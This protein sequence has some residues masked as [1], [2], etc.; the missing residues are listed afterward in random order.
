M[1]V[2]RACTRALPPGT[3]HA[4]NR[5]LPG[6]QHARRADQGVL[7]NFNSD[8]AC[9]G[10]L[11]RYSQGLETITGR[12]KIR[13]AGVA[14]ETEL[15]AAKMREIGLGVEADMHSHEMNVAPCALDWMRRDKARGAAQGK[16]RV[17]RFNA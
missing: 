10:G 12:L 4:S 13:A 7:P 17:D 9:G 15:H 11:P 5:L 1:T 8:L 16:E 2:Q 14:A 6:D 3:A